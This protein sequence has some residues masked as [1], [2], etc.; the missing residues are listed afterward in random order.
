[1]AKTKQEAAAEAAKAQKAAET[2]KEVADR[3]AATKAPSTA[4][5]TGWAAATENW[6]NKLFGGGD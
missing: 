6:L 5:W 1:V 3:A 2:A 4:K